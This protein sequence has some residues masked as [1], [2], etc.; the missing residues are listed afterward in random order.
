MDP[1]AR[2][3]MF[4]AAAIAGIL[5]TGALSLRSRR[6]E[7]TPA[8][9]APRAIQARPPT[10]EAPATASRDARRDPSSSRSSRIPLST[11]VDASD[12]LLGRV[13]HKDGRPAPAGTTVAM[14]TNRP[15]ID[16]PEAAAPPREPRW[17]DARFIEGTWRSLDGATFGLE[18]A[19]RTATAPD[20]TFAIETPR[21]LPFFRLE[22]SWDHGRGQWLGWNE[23]G[24]SAAARGPLL[25]L[26]PAGKVEGVLRGP[27]GAP[28]RAGRV[29]LREVRSHGYGGGEAIQCRCGP[30]G[31]FEMRGVEPGKYEAVSWAEGLG[32]GFG[33]EV[34]VRAGQTVP[35]D[36]RLPPES[37][38]AGTVVDAEGGG[39][40]GAFVLAS[41]DDETGLHV[42]PPTPSRLARTDETGAFRIGS[43]GAG[44]HLLTAELP[45]L[46]L[47]YHN[48][49]E[50][51]HVGGAEGVRIVLEDGRSLA[52]RVVDG[53]GRSVA[54]AIV[55]ADTDWET[56]RKRAAGGP[57]R[58]S[59]QSG[60]TGEDGS[61][62]LTGLADA[63]LRLEVSIEGR[64]RSALPDVE[65][66][67][68]DLLVV[69]HPCG[70]AGT[71]REA[72]TG[73]VVEAF[74]VLGRPFGAP[75]GS[76]EMLDLRPGIA[77]LTV[78]ARGFVPA[79]RPRIELKEGEVIRG[80][81]MRL[82]RAAEVRGRVSADGAPVV[83][84][85]IHWIRAEAPRRESWSW[86]GAMTDANGAFALSGVAPGRIRIEVDHEDFLPATIDS[87]ET[88]AGERL[89]GIEVRLE[90]AGVLEGL[91]FAPD[92]ST[93]A[94]GFTRAKPLAVNRMTFFG[95]GRPV[96]I[97]ADGRFRIA[98]L[99]PGTY[100]VEAYATP[101]EEDG[102]D[103]DPVLRGV[104]WVEAGRTTLVEF[105]EPPPGSSTL[106]GTVRRAGKGLAGISVRVIPAASGRDADLVRIYED[107][108]RTETKAD[109]SY[110]V[111]RVPAGEATLRLDGMPASAGS[112]ALRIPEEGDLVFDVTL[113]SGAIEGTVLRAKDGTPVR[114]GI[115][116]AS[117]A[118]ESSVFRLSATTD[119][120]G[121]YR[122][123]GLAA[124]SHWVRVE[125]GA[126]FEGRAPENSPA[127]AGS[128]FGPVVL[129]EGEVVRGD[130]MLPEGGRGWVRVTDTEGQPKHGAALRVRRTDSP[131]EPFPAWIVGRTDAE[132][133]AEVV[134]LAPGRYSVQA[135]AEGLAAGV[136]DE[137][138][139]TEG[140]VTEIEVTLR[141]GTLVRVRLEGDPALPLLHPVARFRDERGW[142]VSAATDSRRS[143]PSEAFVEAFLA[144][145]EHTLLARPEG[146]R[147][148]SVPVRVG[149]ESPQEIVVT[150]EPETGPPR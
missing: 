86:P 39:V 34:D 80:I 28:A 82:T 21:H 104:A 54:G 26:E 60:R 115:R 109:G 96:A 4:L 113:P 79:T 33:P 105:R 47:S 72:D 69:L 125:Q 75:D 68:E 150:L 106:R 138:A 143:G 89:D 140:D 111:R 93:L 88:R 20:G 128:T 120:E 146:Y 117:A 18:P 48:T 116:V 78:Q 45:G 127:C 50:V 87:L 66:G 13:I 5:V 58:Q 142:N 55:R 77:D 114:A 41:R 64:P 15:E 149:E 37:W 22:A 112:F 92:G 124:G 59:L 122:A 11:V 9:A 38:I 24:D 61:F 29:M 108:F 27:G 44:R 63:P 7:E 23:F 129:G 134:G 131:A 1:R 144:P 49:V 137:F 90:P 3:S 91:A 133:V 17:I 36:L 10:P 95:W 31:R 130:W 94:G 53:E 42:P 103:P 123:E 126:W 19:H 84:A 136:S 43:L 16:F 40:T 62:H 56:I 74:T 98:G 139:V 12:R 71:V 121:R 81:E 145:G 52:G 30:E 119:A 101:I 67:R 51:P 132:G 57:F 97:E 73:K 85:A 46:Q 6:N 65:A 25:I 32:T 99:R 100:R 2:R 102:P 14:F 107:R 35:L 110:E 148:T 70:V 147:A 83:G 76:F 118:G 135:I 8:S 141:R